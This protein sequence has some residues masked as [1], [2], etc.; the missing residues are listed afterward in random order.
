MW[1]NLT[2]ID[3]TDMHG[4]CTVSKVDSLLDYTKMNAVFR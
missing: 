2:G 3:R 1:I 4:E